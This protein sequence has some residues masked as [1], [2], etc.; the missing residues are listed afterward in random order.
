[1]KLVWSDRATADLHAIFNYIETRNPLSA[2]KV[3]LQIATVAEQLADF[4][5]L[6]RPAEV[7]GIR[8][9]QVPHRPYLLPYRIFGNEVEILA[10]FDERMNCPREW[11]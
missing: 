1:V 6:G 11:M 10:V 2:Q 9:L 5:E 7:S 8:L 3:M 4:P